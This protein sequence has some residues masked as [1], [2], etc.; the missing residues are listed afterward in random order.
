[1][2]PSPDTN[3]RP[4]PLSVVTICRD[5]E[6]TIGSVLESVAGLASEIV[7]VD[8]GSEDRT[9]AICRG[10]GAR[11]IERAWAGFVGTK[12]IALE[13]ARENWVL[14]LD[15]DEP[16]TPGLAASIRA[17]LE[18]DD[19]GVAGARVR[20][21]V[22]YRGKP[23][24]HAWQP[25]WRVRLVRRSL[26]E[27]GAARW[28]GADPH[29]RLLIDAGAGRVVD[30]EGVLRHDSFA[31]FTEHLG[32]Q[33]A[34]ARTAAR[35]LREAGGRGS[36]WKL[37]TSPAGAF[38]KQIVIKG[39]WRDGIP[40]WLAA[41]TTAAGTLM[42]HMILLESGLGEDPGGAY[43]PGAGSAP[44][45]GGDPMDDARAGPARRHSGPT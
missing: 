41:G 7:A 9:V 21:V 3:A 15:S 40:G 43:A 22:W 37:A 34:H 12:Q 38:L 2:M 28:G 14:H 32:K 25:E 1:M 33:L 17:L 31:S 16:V 26:V 18:T 29:D 19:P 8:S 44:T 35:S 13:S 27:R 23:L 10:L 11:V 39:A 6:A 4:L 42:K 30:L 5:N 45:D 36:V 20:R 24:N